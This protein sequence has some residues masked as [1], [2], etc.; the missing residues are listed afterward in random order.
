MKTWKALE[1]FDFLY[2]KE[3]LRVLKEYEVYI[4]MSILDWI[5]CDLLLRCQ[6]Q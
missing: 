6:G 4:D 5:E 3:K 2:L 1:A